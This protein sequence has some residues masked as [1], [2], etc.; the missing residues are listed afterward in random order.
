MARAIRQLK[1]K[2]AKRKSRQKTSRRQ[3]KRGSRNPL[4]AD[5][6]HWMLLKD[7]YRQFRESGLEPSEAGQRLIA[8]LCQWPLM[9]C[10][11]R[12]VNSGREKTLH[13]EDWEN[14]W[15]SLSIETDPTNGAD[16]L[17]T[18]DNHY[19]HPALSEDDGPAEFLVPT[20]NVAHERERLIAASPAPGKKPTPRKKLSSKSRQKPA[21]KRRRTKR[22]SRRGP[23]NNPSIA[24]P[25]LPPPP[26]PSPPPPAPQTTVGA[27][28]RAIAHLKPLLDR[29]R[30]AMSK[31]EAW[32]E[33]KQF[34][35]SRNGFENHVWPTARERAGLE[36]KAR[37]GKKPRQPKEIEQEVDQILG[38][39]PGKKLQ[40][41]IEEEGS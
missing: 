1:T 8:L 20:A 25:P 37:A 19:S 38:P 10:K 34:T 27:E 41:L 26:S 15:V 11:I 18:H 16:C 2:S 31:D 32:K 9:P 29:R 24:A 4:K 3:S 17:G 14:E 30:D 13:V 7:A 40:K 28:A 36:R 23:Q 5:S 12:Y 6:S 22:R 33:C 39:A 35:I 21:S